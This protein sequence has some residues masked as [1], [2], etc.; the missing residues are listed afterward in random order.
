MGDETGLKSAAEAATEA[1][2]RSKYNVMFMKLL[3]L[4]APGIA[5]VAVG[6]FVA[7]LGQSGSYSRKLTVFAPSESFHGVSCAALDVE[8]PLFF[9][10]SSSIWTSFGS[11]VRGTSVSPHGPTAPSTQTLLGRRRDSTDPTST[12][13]AS[14][15]QAR[16]C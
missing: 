5:V 11:M 6:L 12:Y 3:F 15:R 14:R 9:R 16:W 10:S 8:D 2:E 4:Q 1:A 13:T 7:F